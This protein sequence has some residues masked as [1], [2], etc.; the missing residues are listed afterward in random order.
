MRFISLDQKPSWF[1]K[2]GHKKTLAQKGGPA[3]G[4]KENFSQT[5]ERYTILTSVWSW[6]NGDR[7][8]PPPVA[9]LFKGKQKGDIWKK[10]QDHALNDKTWM[11]VQCQENGS[12]R[13]ADVVEA[14]DWM[15]PNATCSLESIIVLLDWFSGHLT[16]EVAE[17]IREKGHVLLFHGGGTT[18]IHGK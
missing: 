3:P 15:L 16:D 5:R 13:S 17:K 6:D 7:S 12:Y 14:L 2:A 9:V 11:R 1:N 4:V 18:P 8:K 10:L